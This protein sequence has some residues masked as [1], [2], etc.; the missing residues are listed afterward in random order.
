[1]KLTALSLRLP[2]AHAFTI[3]RETM[4]W[5][6][7]IVVE[8]EHDG[9]VGYG[10]VTENQFY[11][12]P[13]EAILSSIARARSFIEAYV[14]GNPLELWDQ[15]LELLEGDTFAASAIDMA[16]HDWRGKKLG[17]PTWKVWGL[18]W[19]KTPPSSYTIGIDTIP[20]MIA[21][22]E[23]QP[24]WPIYKIKLGTPHDLEIVQQLRSK[25]EARFRV[26]ANCAWSAEQTVE[27]S[28]ALKGL[29]V[30]FIEQPLPQS[31]SHEDKQWVYRNSR[32][33][34]LA[35]EDC[36]VPRDVGRCAETYHGI[37]VKICKCGGLTP[38]LRM[39]RE[40]RTLGLRT[41]VGC[42]V[43]SSIGIS[44]AAQLLPLLDYA[45]LDGAVL[46]AH[47]PATG[48]IVESGHVLQTDRPGN[49]SRLLSERLDAYL[50]P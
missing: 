6:T 49:G 10:E 24:N 22:L 18:E 4:D 28:I 3:S 29:G 15:L 8:L 12:H 32:L 45:D 47:E 37:N 44:G 11:G 36:Q 34:I 43:E 27:N 35:D 31:A 33:P 23:E 41:M 39:L 21:K 50:L 48:V 5:Q 17:Q 42:M 9:I 13:R 25:T 38:A 19:E 16:A 26:D 2:L 40:A 20:K 30:E 1:M 46:L 7:S 14:A